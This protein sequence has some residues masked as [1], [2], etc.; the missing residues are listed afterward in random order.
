M[1]TATC[2]RCGKQ[3]LVK[4]A[5]VFVFPVDFVDLTT[6][7][8]PSFSGGDRPSKHAQRYEVCEDC[9]PGVKGEF[10]AKPAAKQG[11]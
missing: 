1:L 6:P 5:I 8:P 11:R 4:T 10:I 9:Y 3:G 2:D 7:P